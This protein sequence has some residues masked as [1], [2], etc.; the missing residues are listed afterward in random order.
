[1][2]QTQYHVVDPFQ[3]NSVM[4]C[5]TL[6][7]NLNCLNPGLQP[8]KPTVFL[9]TYLCFLSG[10]TLLFFFQNQ[11]P[12]PSY[13]FDGTSISLLSRGKEIPKALLP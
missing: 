5:S 1:M 13:I 11:K 7:S 12:K 2:S 10:T 4:G 3:N 6:E 9:N 8:S